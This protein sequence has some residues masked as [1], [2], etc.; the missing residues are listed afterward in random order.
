M[1]EHFPIQRERRGLR[2]SS[3][4]FYGRVKIKL[5]LILEQSYILT[6]KKN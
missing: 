2:G 4:I 5:C 1:G 6:G 3:G